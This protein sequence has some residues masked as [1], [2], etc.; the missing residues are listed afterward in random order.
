MGGWA[1]YREWDEHN[2]NV[3]LRKARHALAQRDAL[4]AKRPGGW[5]AAERARRARA[6]EAR[7]YLQRLNELARRAPHRPRAEAM[8]RQL[9]SWL[10]RP[11]A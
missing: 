10:E 7:V 4:A 11:P 9:T 6:E 3:H 2:W 1:M 5:A 8:V